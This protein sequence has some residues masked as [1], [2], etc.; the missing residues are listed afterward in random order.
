M[1]D[2]LCQSGLANRLIEN[3]YIYNFAGGRGFR[4]Y[5]PCRAVGKDQHSA[6]CAR[7]L[8]GGTQQPVDQ[9]FQDDFG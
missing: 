1:D 2:R 9:P 4:R 7:V 3:V 5:P 6:L 8:D